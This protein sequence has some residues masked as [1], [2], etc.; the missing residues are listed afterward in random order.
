M[1]YNN[2]SAISGHGI[3]CA[4]CRYSE[5]SGVYILE[6]EWDAARTAFD[7]LE[8][9]RTK[10]RVVRSSF[11]GNTRLVTESYRVRQKDDHPY[12]PLYDDACFF[13]DHRETDALKLKKNVNWH[14]FLAFDD[15]HSQK[16]VRVVVCDKCYFKKHYSR[17]K[18]RK[19]W[20]LSMMLA[21]AEKRRMRR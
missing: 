21:M 13:C 15:K 11:S 6:E 10:K 3:T 20:R 12:L 5:N 4:R 19:E 9:V 14:R 7:T 18:Y 2:L 8:R 17:F 1:V 16:F